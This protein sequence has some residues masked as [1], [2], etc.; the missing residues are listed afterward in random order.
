MVTDIR[1]RAPHPRIQSEVIGIINKL[2]QMT[3][4]RQRGV[5]VRVQYTLPITFH[6]KE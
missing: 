3:P 1:A 6:V 5:P 4:G 2:P